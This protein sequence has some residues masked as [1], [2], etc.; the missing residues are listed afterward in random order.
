ML[1]HISHAVRQQEL[2][3]IA[4]HDSEKNFEQLCAKLKSDLH[5][6]QKMFD[7]VSDQYRQQQE[8]L[9]RLSRGKD[10]HIQTLLEEKLAIKMKTK[11]YG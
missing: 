6:M 5:S 3:D 4:Q 11:S 9:E 1:L 10:Y 7:G 2:P 8:V